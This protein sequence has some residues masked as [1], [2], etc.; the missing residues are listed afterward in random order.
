MRRGLN[1]QHDLYIG[2]VVVASINQPKSAGYPRLKIDPQKGIPGWRSTVD[3][4]DAQNEEPAGRRG[5]FPYPR[6][7]RGKTITYNVIG[8]VE[9]GDGLDGLDEYMDELAAVFQDTSSL[10]LIVSTP[11]PGLPGGP[12]DVWSSFCRVL[13]FTADEAQLRGPTAAPSPWQRDA[14]LSLRLLDGRWGWLNESGTPFEPVSWENLA[15]EA[16]AVTNSGRAPTP[17]VITVHGVDPGDD[18]HVGRD[19]S[20]SWPAQQLW[21]RDPVGAAGFAVAKDVVIDFGALP[22]HVTVDGINVTKSYDA[23]ASDWWDEFVF[24][25]PPGTHNVWRGP[26]AGTG[27]EVHFYSCSW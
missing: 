4:D 10:A 6:T 16:V 27:I 21:F 7:G 2:G 17:P 8:Q 24:E 1:A 5:E 18:L 3:A 23:A 13:A 22:R 12:D 11:W 9:W 25:I 19:A 26:G 15:G 20:G 14:Q